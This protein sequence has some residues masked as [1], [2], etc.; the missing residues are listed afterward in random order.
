M[1]LF[2]SSCPFRIIFLVFENLTYWKYLSF[3]LLVT[4]YLPV[5][6]R[7]SIEE[8]QSKKVREQYGKFGRN[9]NTSTD[10]L[11]KTEDAHKWREE[12]LEFERNA[13]DKSGRLLVIS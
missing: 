12:V 11:I 9:P 8:F 10:Q 2:R 7:Q 4:T 6:M 1:H 5:L 13:F 3:E